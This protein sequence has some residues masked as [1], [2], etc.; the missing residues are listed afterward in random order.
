MTILG[1]LVSIGTLLAFTTVCIGVLVLR[2]T[3]PDL[4]RPFRVRAPWFVCI[5][6]ALIC[7]AMMLSLPRDT[8]L[9]LARLD[10]DR[11]PDL[12]VLRLP[13]Q[14]A[15]QERPLKREPS[16]RRQAGST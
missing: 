8:W 4:K 3:R 16:K 11:V 14:R 2:Y 10:R 15:A 9:R 12:R 1:E 6:G 13:Q 5:G 7:S